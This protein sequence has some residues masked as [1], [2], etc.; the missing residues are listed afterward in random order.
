MPQNYL[1]GNINNL[2]TAT[3]TV[4]TKTKTAASYW[5]V[6]TPVTPVITQND[7]RHKKKVKMKNIIKQKQKQ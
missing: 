6:K 7:G 3:A 4:A 2:A 5:I 1:N